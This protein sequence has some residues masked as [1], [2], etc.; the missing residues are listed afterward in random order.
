MVRLV[1]GSREPDIVAPG[2]PGEQKLTKETK[3]RPDSDIVD[4]K[5][6]EQA[7]AALYERR[8]IGEIHGPALIRFACLAKPRLSAAPATRRTSFP[9]V[10]N[11]PRL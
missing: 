4:A 7:V 5:V 3:V 9:S 10:Q 2:K 1:I 6:I 8:C 11:P